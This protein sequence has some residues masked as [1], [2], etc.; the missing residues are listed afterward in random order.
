MRRFSEA[1]ASLGT[2]FRRVG[3]S[4]RGGTGVA[5]ARMRRTPES[6]TRGATLIDVLV[7][8]A[9]TAVVVGTALP[10]LRAFTEPYALDTASR[11]LAADVAAARMRAIA[12]NRRH[13]IVFSA[14]GGWWELQAENAPGSFTPVGARHTLPDGCTFTG[15]DANPTFDTR[16]MLAADFEAEISAAGAKRTVDVN[17]LGD[18]TVSKAEAV[19]SPPVGG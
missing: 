8:I 6:R 14:D 9:L 1:L 5:N 15:L 17:V 19:Q 7:G 18:T 3:R 16:G 12:Q 4:R 13:R 2:A 10:N 11:L